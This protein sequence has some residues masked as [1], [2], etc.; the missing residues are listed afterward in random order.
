MVAAFLIC[1][2]SKPLEGQSYFISWIDTRWYKEPTHHPSLL[3]RDQIAT[4]RLMMLSWVKSGL[5]VKANE[6]FKS[7]SSYLHI[8][9]SPKRRVV[10]SFVNC[11][12][13]NDHRL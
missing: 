8:P 3:V 2:C 1:V 12:A 5:I 11:F 4:L 6:N 7:E 10:Q 13:R 9:I